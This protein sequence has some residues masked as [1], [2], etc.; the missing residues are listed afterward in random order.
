MTKVVVDQIQRPGGPVVE[1]PSVSPTG[2]QY[3]QTDAAGLLSFT[4][5]STVTGVDA[6][7]A[8]SAPYIFAV[9]S[10][11]MSGYTSS[12]G[13]SSELGDLQSNS[14]T[15]RLNVFAL[16][17]GRHP[18]G[19]T[20]GPGY[21]NYMVP[22]M[23]CYA[24][25]TRGESSFMRNQQCY[26][27]STNR[28]N[29]ADKMISTFFFKNPTAS[30]I[31]PTIGF[32]GSSNRNSS[33]DGMSV[34][35]FTPNAILNPTSL[36]YTN[37]LNYAT[38]SGSYNTTFSFSV[39]AGFTVALVFYSSYYNYSNPSQYCLYGANMVYNL[40]NAFAAGLVIDIPRTMK[41]IS[42][43]NKYGQNTS[44]ALA[45]IWS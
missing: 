39:A 16:G 6:A 11:Y 7:P 9:N 4:N 38:N 19:K 29:Y 10:S 43:P 13:F 31:T 28:Y 26:P 25:G 30:T 42:N 21:A 22:P 36:T 45:E 20:N 8:A 35:Q 32:R 15:P 18:W 14:E 27:D 2:N 1:L 23:I 33:Y 3:L 34:S 37:L 17:T 41:A 12:G 5:Q 24:M 44:A 40:S